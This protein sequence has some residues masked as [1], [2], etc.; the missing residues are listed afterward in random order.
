MK[1]AINDIRAETLALSVNER[2]CLAHALL[3]SLD[4]PDE[5]EL[6]PEQEEEIL[7]RVRTV[8]DGKAA[9][10]SLE[11]VAAEIRANYGK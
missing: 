3:L 5:L 8:R 10:N 1:K 7:R 6:E 2:A 11:S 9:G 4:D